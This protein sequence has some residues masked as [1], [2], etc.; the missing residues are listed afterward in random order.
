M[1]FAAK[2]HNII[3]FNL[4]SDPEH[5]IQLSIEP[6]SIKIYVSRNTDSTQLSIR[7]IYS[8]LYRYDV[9]SCFSIF[10]GILIWK[11]KVYAIEMIKCT[12]RMDAI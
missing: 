3:I 8:V 4:V 11:N 7:T 12:T 5:Y 10:A 9:K 6:S 1:Q 2:L